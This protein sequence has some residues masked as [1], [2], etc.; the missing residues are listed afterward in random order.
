MDEEEF[1]FIVEEEDVA[2]RIDKYL[3]EQL[4]S[5]AIELPSSKIGTRSQVAVWLNDNRIL[6]N[7][8]VVSRA[9]AR[10]KLGDVVSG[11]SSL[12]VP[13]AVD[14]DDSI[15]LTIV[16]EDSE[17]LLLNKQAGLVVHPGAGVHEG[18]LVNALL[19]H[20]GE[21][22]RDVGEAFRPGIVHRLDKDTSGLMLVAKNPRSQQ[23]I[24][25]QFLPPREIHR[26]YLA[27]TRK[28]PSFGSDSGTIEGA[29]ARHPRDRKK[30][31]VRTE[32]KAATTHWELKEAFNDA[33]LLR[34]KLETG[35]TH[36]IRVHL[37][38]RGS[39][40]L[41]DPLYGESVG[42]LPPKLRLPAASLSFIHPKS[43]E[44][45][46]FECELPEDMQKVLDVFKD[47]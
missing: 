32:G 45:M 26:E 40:I 7:G 6:C 41:G 28:L 27:F 9:S 10:L 12:L 2:K 31:A 23:F 30:M 37:A 3:S 33:Y 47:D 34:L 4:L 1:S 11:S 19:H 21:G 25:E 29:I 16:Y 17:L 8:K 43:G 36:Q 5:S 46:N 14:A 18:T 44:R 24:S 13:L 39:S 22:F 42:A 38:D 20:L 15:P 35:R